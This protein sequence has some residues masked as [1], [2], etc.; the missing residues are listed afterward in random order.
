MSTT[1]KDNLFKSS[2]PETFVALSGRQYTPPHTSKYDSS[3]DEAPVNLIYVCDGFEKSKI[4]TRGGKF[5]CAFAI[6]GDRSERIS[7]CASEGLSD[8]CRLCLTSGLEKK[9]KLR[10]EQYATLVQSVG[11]PKKTYRGGYK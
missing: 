11:Y 3:P 2:C 1:L 4:S 5:T 8:C 7:V 9:M 6:R 10:P